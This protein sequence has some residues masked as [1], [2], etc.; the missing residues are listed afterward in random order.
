MK[1]ENDLQEIAHAIVETF[2]AQSRANFNEVIHF[3][4]YHGFQIF[5]L[6]NK[7]I[8][9][10]LSNFDYQPDNLEIEVVKVVSN[11]RDQIHY[12]EGSSA[13]IHILGASHGFENPKNAFAYQDGLWI[14]VHD[15]EERLIPPKTVHGFTVEE[16]GVLFFLSVQY[17]PIVTEVKDDYHPAKDL[18]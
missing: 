2:N 12:H 9:S 8:D 6:P 4:D 13:F 14:A 3:E 11:L 18:L 7:L 17:P 5:S 16:D 10:V 1:K 15:G